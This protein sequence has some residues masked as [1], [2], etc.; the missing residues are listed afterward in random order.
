MDVSLQ[1]QELKANPDRSAQGTVIDASLDK[2]RGVLATVLVQNG[3]LHKGDVVLCGGAYGKVLRL[4]F[5]DWAL[6]FCVEFIYK[7][8]SFRC[9]LLNYINRV[10]TLDYHLLGSKKSSNLRIPQ[11]VAQRICS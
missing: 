5:R 6:E 2:A 4:F 1:L 10:G 8:L 9:G 3:T 11:C 7:P